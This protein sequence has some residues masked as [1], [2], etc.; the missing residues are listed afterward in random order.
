MKKV[1]ITRK[2][3]EAG[4]KILRENGIEFYMADHKLP[5][6]QKEI[7]KNLKKYPYDGVINFLT[8][9]I[10]SKVFDACPTAKVYAN[11]SVGFDNVDME[12]AKRRCIEVSNTPN[13]SAVDVAEHTVALILAL[14]TRIVEG[15]EFIR[16][17]K[18]KGWDP[19]LFIGTDLKGKT[20]GLIG[21]GQIGTKVAQMLHNG[22]DV[23][24]IYHD[25]NENK[26]LEES[27]KVIKKEFI[28]VI[29]EADIISLHVPLLP[30]TK[31]MIN[32]EILSQMK[33]TAI[34]INTAR[35][36]IVDEKA[37]L[38]ALKEGTISGAGIDVYEFEPKITKGLLKLDNIIMTPHIASS[39]QSARNMMAEIA[40][41]N[42]VSA[43]TTGKV[44]DSC[45][46]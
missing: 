28:D 27:F 36:A 39:R 44:I 14:C 23:N 40:A 29:K 19:N 45:H 42:I 4:L 1:Y 38:E 16:K 11:F 17:G 34:L 24:I 15:D 43:L 20:I 41:K 10:D 3:P 37:L 13:T 25:I 26:E 2:I 12:E 5:P 32:K 33:K 18:Y 46:K 22:F 9:K 30:S 31:H 7:I 6:T 8:D 35:G 21:G